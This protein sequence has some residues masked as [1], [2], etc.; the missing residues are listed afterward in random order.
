M[1]RWQ[2]IVIA[3]GSLIFA[4]ALLPSVL[5]KHKPALWTSAMTG[6]VL[7]VF[8]ITYATLSLLYA[9]ITTSFAALLW[10]ILAIQKMLEPK[11]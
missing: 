10:I 7:V 9:T 6:T 3:V 5:S 4:I 11:E 8:T 1:H 2:D